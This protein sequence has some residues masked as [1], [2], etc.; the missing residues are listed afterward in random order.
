[1][2]P[3]DKAKPYGVTITRGSASD[4]NTLRRRSKDMKQ[5]LPKCSR[6]KYKSWTEYGYE[7]SCNAVHNEG[8]EDCLC[9]YHENGGRWHPETSGLDPDHLTDCVVAFVPRIKY[10]ESFKYFKLW[11][12][13]DGSIGSN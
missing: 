11:K 13:E 10:P 12:V 9:N 2:G 5:P 8:C 7:Y 4:E 6:H 3:E 1:M